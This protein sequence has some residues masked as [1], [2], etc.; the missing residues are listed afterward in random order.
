MEHE[1]VFI[2]EDSA[3]G[4]FKA[5]AIGFSI[6]VEAENFAQLKQNIREAVADNFEK[7]IISKIVLAYIM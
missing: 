5:N 3:D 2:V 6:S 7:N 1:I 4:S